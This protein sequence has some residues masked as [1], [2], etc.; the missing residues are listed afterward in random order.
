MTAGRPFAAVL[1]HD[2]LSRELREVTPG[3]DGILRFYSCGPTIHDVP[4]IGNG[5]MFAW[6][7]LFK[8]VLRARGY[9][10]RD[11][12]N[13][14]DV[15]DKIIERSRAAG[16]DVTDPSRLPEYTAAYE[17]AFRDDLKSLRVLPPAFMPRATEFVPRM[18]ELVQRLVERGHA[19]ES[20]GSVYFSVAS[21]P[22]YGRLAHLE[23][24]ENVAGARVAADEYEKDDVRDF[25]LWKASKPGEPRWTSPWGDGRPGWHIECSVMAMDCLGSETIDVHVGGEDLVFPHH[26]NE[27]AQSEGATGKPFC[28]VWVHCAHLRVDGTKMSK[29][30]GNFHTIR[31]LVAKGCDPIA[32][33]YLLTSVHYRAPLNLTMEGLEAAQAT[34]DRLNEFARMLSTARPSPSDDAVLVA[35]IVRAARE[36]EESLAAD[37]NTSQALGVLF[38]I[39][40]DVNAAHAAGRMGPAAL[41]SAKKLLELADSIFA[42]LPEGG[43]G[44]RTIAREIAGKAYE[45][46]GPADMAD[47]VVDKVFARQEARKAR[48]FAKADAARDALT[49][50]GWI[51]E[52]VPGGARVKKA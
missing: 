36:F 28:K 37:L 4:H 46:T 33:R 29:S 22:G 35:S 14:T 41:A 44:V 13:I 47:D 42:F 51:V 12:M 3:A 9:D 19:Y 5:R 17:S 43:A 8:R 15:E 27:I 30:L 48:D 34:V 2:T 26:E 49:Q 50:A 40:R 45:V 6:Q 7:D 31:D 20:D 32:I 24:R 16:I 25:V 11:V 52:D 21:L 1:V 18:V 39:V 10:V 38:G 23:A